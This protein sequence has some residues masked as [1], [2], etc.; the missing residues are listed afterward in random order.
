VVTT[1][2]ARFTR[3][4]YMRLPEGFPAQ[5]V[6][7]WLIKDPAPT[8]LHQRVARR[9]TFAFAEHVGEERILDAPLDLFLDD[10]N[11]YQPDVLVFERIPRIES[12]EREIEH[13]VLV[14]EVLS[15]STA[16]YDRGIKAR[17]YLAAG[18]L[19]VWL[20]DPEDGTVEIRSA[21]GR[22][23]FGSGDLAESR[24]IE[25]LAVEVD[26]LFRR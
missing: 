13:P 14:V 15:G 23:Q 3:N 4:D 1:A 10:T 18:V 6:D 8:P 12:R 7:G 2:P 22:V 9:I 26:R 11:V 25:G 5:L 21:D 17:R 20:V 16:S 19:E 24:S